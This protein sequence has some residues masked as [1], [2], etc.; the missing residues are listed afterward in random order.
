MDEIVESATVAMLLAAVLV[1]L[2]TKGRFKIFTGEVELTVNVAMFSKA[3][4]SF[5]VWFSIDSKK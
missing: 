5:F 2:L 1:T 4:G 3:H